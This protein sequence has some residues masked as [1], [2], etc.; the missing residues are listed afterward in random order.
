MVALWTVMIGE[1]FRSLDIF[2]HLLPVAK[3]KSKQV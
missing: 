2:S 3:R 1:L